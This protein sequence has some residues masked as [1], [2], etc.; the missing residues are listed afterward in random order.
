MNM[1]ISEGLLYVG[2]SLADDASLGLEESFD[3]FPEI[4]VELD[5]LQSK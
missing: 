2:D 1:G 3:F 5:V 4:F